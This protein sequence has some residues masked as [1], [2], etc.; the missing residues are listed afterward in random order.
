MQGRGQNDPGV[1]G[2][3]RWLSRLGGHQQG[4]GRGAGQGLGVISSAVSHIERLDFTPSEVETTADFCAKQRQLPTE[5]AKGQLQL[6]SGN[7]ALGMYFTVESI[8]LTRHCKWG[9]RGRASARTPGFEAERNLLS[10]PPSTW[11]A[12]LSGL[13]P[14]WDS[15]EAPADQNQEPGAADSKLPRCRPRACVRLGRGGS[16][17]PTPSTGAEI[18]SSSP[19][20]GRPQRRAGGCFATGFEGEWG[21][22]ICSICQFL[23]CRRSHCG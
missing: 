4:R 12:G 15:R 11:W 23:W 16:Q 18:L 21:S 19:D 22:L 10:E 3:T 14:R 17:R 6:L 1:P 5:A 20:S 9:G 2:V 7:L 13:A 8:Q